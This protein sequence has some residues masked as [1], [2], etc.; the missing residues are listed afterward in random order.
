MLLPILSISLIEKMLLDQAFNASVT[1]SNT[2][3]TNNLP[4]RIS[5]RLDQ[6]DAAIGAGNHDKTSWKPAMIEWFTTARAMIH[7]GGHPRG[8]AQDDPQECNDLREGIM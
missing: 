2:T 4:V 3:I 5:L 1:F 6:A 8:D 7:H